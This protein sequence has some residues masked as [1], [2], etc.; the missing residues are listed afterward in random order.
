MMA[1]IFNHLW[2]STMFAAV[3]ALLCFACRRNRARLRY[4]LWLVASAKFLV[5]M[6]RQPIAVRLA[7]GQVIDA[8]TSP[9]LTAD[10]IEAV[11]I[12]APQGVRPAP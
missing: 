10:V 5:Q 3:V 9:L 11:P 7:S 12:E 4:G 8:P 1:D 2:Q 6:P